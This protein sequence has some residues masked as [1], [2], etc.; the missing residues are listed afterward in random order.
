MKIIKLKLTVILLM[1]LG[2]NLQSQIHII[3]QPLEV[4]IEEGFFIL[5]D[6]VKIVANKETKE[7]AKILCSILKEG[8]DKKTKI[9]KKGNGIQLLINKELEKNLDKEG[10]KLYSNN[11][12]IV[13]EGATKA[14]LFY[15]IQSFKQLLPSDFGKEN[16]KNKNVDFPIVQIADKPRF[17][18]R[19]QIV[20]VLLPY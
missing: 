2:L 14:G 8:F 16:Y 15:G 18:W 19:Y 4:S 13:I 17:S 3:P 12:N 11:K 10:Y 20:F 1:F 7:E 9:T 6:D 5:N